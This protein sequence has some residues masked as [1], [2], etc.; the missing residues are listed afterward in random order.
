[1]IFG[2]PFFGLA[3]GYGI[4]AFE[5]KIKNDKSFETTYYY[6]DY[7]SS[8]IIFYTNELEESYKE[9]IFTN[10]AKDLFKAKAKMLISENCIKYHLNILNEPNDYEVKEKIRKNIRNKIVYNNSRRDNLESKI[11]HSN[12]NHYVYKMTLFSDIVRDKSNINLCNKQ[13]PSVKLYEHVLP[14]YIKEYTERF[15][16]SKADVKDSTTAYYLKQEKWLQ[17]I[18]KHSIQ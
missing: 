13:L 7:N 2:I 1:M 8:A 11:N 5:Q 9:Y 10:T 12:L 17:D 6:R 18:T 4:I 3:I 15:K 16:V 14:L